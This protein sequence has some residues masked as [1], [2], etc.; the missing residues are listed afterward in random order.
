MLK[1]G[2]Q[3]ATYFRKLRFVWITDKG[4]LLVSMSESGQET[5]L[6]ASRQSTTSLSAPQSRML[7]GV[8]HQ[9]RS[10]SNRLHQRQHRLRIECMIVVITVRL[11]PPVTAHLDPP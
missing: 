6:L 10:L 7:D 11:L 5:T 9:R 3:P 8:R 1:S 4:D 2:L